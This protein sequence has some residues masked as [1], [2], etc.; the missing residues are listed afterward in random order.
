ME[1]GPKVKASRLLR[2]DH[3]KVQELYQ[4]FIEAQITSDGSEVAEEICKEL[5]IHTWLE[6]RLA[7]PALA[8]AG[9][10]DLARQL[11][12]EHGEI[13]RLI[14][15]WRLARDPDGGRGAG[16]PFT[17]L[18]T[19]VQAH[20]EGEERQGL[21]A[22]AR[23]PSGDEDLGAALAR[24]RLKLKMFPPFQRSVDLDVPVSSAYAQW[25]RYEEFPR[26]LDT[27]REVRRLDAGRV[28]WR[29]EVGGRELRWTAEIYEQVPDQRIAWRSV[30]GAVH[31]GS[32][33]FRPLGP[34]LT[35][36]LVE[37]AYE[38]QGLVEDLGALLGLV[39]QRVAAE[40]ERFK[41]F[42]ESAPR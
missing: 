33:S 42:V 19:V 28:Q 38:P 22:L 6:E 29:A 13:R 31:A 12:L 3:Q 20:V 11:A 7:G 35:R 4:N 36:M 30:E 34:A 18:M 16:V 40:L 2:E 9:G 32:V 17:Q 21:P 37:V 26:F 41:A 10:A 25:T 24:L 1:M 5:E 39:S 15:Q 23:D 14:S 8:R 27:I